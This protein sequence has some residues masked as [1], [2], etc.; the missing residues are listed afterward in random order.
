MIPRAPREKTG[1]ETAIDTALSELASFDAHSE[2]YSTIVDQIAKLH[3]L[4]EAEKP[5]RVSRDVLITVGG[6]LLAV[7][8]IVGYERSN[9]VTSKAL[10]FLKTAR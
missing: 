1:L 3:E 9:V 4:K 6:N 7:A 10:A 8:F 5:S 2:E